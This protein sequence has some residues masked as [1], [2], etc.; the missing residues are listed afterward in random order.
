MRA[1]QA[2]RTA[3]HAPRQ[4]WVW[5]RALTS[6]HA[7]LRACVIDRELAR[8]VPSWR[9]PVYAARS[10]QVTSVRSRAALAHSLEDL[11]KRAGLPRSHS[12]GSAVIEPC[13]E[14][15]WHALPQIRGLSARL[16][17]R[18]PI[19]SRGAAGLLE[20]LRDGTG[21]CYNYTHHGALSTVLNRVAAWLDTEE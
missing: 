10:L 5:P 7:R 2:V 18:E 17:S 14:Q 9:S 20:L 16:R 21:P 3:A 15:V 13:R 6:L 8:G 1:A 4:R 12:V 19:S 11:V